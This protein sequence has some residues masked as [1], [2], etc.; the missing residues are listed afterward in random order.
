MKMFIIQYPVP[1]SV[2]AE[3][4]NPG[5]LD[6]GFSSTKKRILLI[7]KRAGETSLGDLASALGISKM[8][9]LRHLTILETKELVERSTKSSG[10]GRPRAFFR[11]TDRSANLF[12]HAYAQMTVAALDFIDERLGSDAVVEL[13]EARARQVYDR[14]HAKFDGKDLRDKVA[15]LAQIRDE[16]GY[17]A[18]LGT[19]R[20]GTV[21]MLE[22]NC[23]I[24][25]IAGTYGEACS[26]ERALFENLLHAEVDTTH[27]VVAGAPVCRFLIRKREGLRDTGGA[28]GI[29]LKREQTGR[30]R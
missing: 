7:L 30:T 21:E 17:M 16:E 3:E 22:H 13:L 12:P 6:A 27:R 5:S 26:V 2:A 10:R 1:P 24:V 15:L 4:A 29:L 14:H 25:A 20:R 23:P 9:T 18:E 8:A 28:T 11:L 19:T